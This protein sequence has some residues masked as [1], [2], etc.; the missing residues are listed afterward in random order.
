VAAELLTIDCGNSTITC[1][2]HG[3]GARCSTASAD[4]QLDPCVGLFRAG[5]RVLAVSVV[6]SA[7]AAVQRAFAATAGRVEVVGDD[8]GCPLALDYS[9]VDTLGADRW[10][11]AFAAHHRFGCAVTVDC[12]TATTV[13]LV[14]ADARFRGGAIGPGLAALAAGLA[15]KAPA[16]PVADLDAEPVVPA[17]TSQQSVDAGVLLG[18][19]GL[20]ERLVSEVR[21]ASPEP[22]TIVLTGGNAARVR[23]RVAFAAHLW[24]DLLHDGMAA[25]A[26]RER[27]GS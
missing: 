10:L 17:P 21:S 27:C 14:T 4:P 9:T 11:G 6:P 12:G 23:G 13:N 19:A 18:Y 5:M 20:V 15:A 8:L 26:A 16:L 1:L 3:D 24:P 22:P 7:L 2:R 25:L